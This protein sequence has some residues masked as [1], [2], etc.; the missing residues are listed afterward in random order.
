[1]NLQ[2]P[3][4][5]NYEEGLE[6]YNSGNLA[7][8][9]EQYRKSIELAYNDIPMDQLFVFEKSIE[10]AQIYLESNQPQNVLPYASQAFNIFQSNRSEVFSSLQCR[11]TV[12]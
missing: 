12:S 1:M 7:K 4:Q 2:D 3:K 9:I 11:V 8:A 5:A 6:E 10:L